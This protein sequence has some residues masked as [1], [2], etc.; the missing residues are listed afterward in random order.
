MYS[1][2]R[3]AVIPIIINDALNMMSISESMTSRF[4]RDSKPQHTPLDNGIQNRNL[5]SLSDIL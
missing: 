4:F 3:K 2:L 5:G 1:C